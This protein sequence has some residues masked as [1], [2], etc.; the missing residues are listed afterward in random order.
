MV[1]GWV[2][3]S[4]CNDGW[5]WLLVTRLW[6]ERRGGGESLPRRRARWLVVRL[7]VVKDWQVAGVDGLVIHL[8]CSAG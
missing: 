6:W 8:W 2:P 4:W 3:R 7:V 1:G 5:T